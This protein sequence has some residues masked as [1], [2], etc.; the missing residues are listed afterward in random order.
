MLPH[1]LGDIPVCT[2]FFKT[3]VSVQ[4]RGSPG[5]PAKKNQGLA[6]DFGFRTTFYP[7]DLFIADTACG[8]KTVELGL[9]CLAVIVDA[10][11]LVHGI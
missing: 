9:V 8:Q 5:F 7:E 1:Y 6:N 3:T 2:L 10:K 4:C 11:G